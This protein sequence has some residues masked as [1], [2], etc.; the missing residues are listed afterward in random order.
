MRWVSVRTRKYS[1]LCRENP[2][3][4]SVVNN[5]LYYLVFFSFFLRADKYRYPRFTAMVQKHYSCGGPLNATCAWCGQSFMA[6]NFH[7]V[8]PFSLAVPGS[9]RFNATGRS[10]GGRERAHE[11]Y[12]E[13]FI[14]LP[15]AR[16]LSPWPTQRRICTQECLANAMGECAN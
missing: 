15:A 13:S 14:Q 1:Q 11:I 8:G 10:T 3:V 9:T 2:E 4:Q 7:S 16:R 6:Y 5:E 12:Y